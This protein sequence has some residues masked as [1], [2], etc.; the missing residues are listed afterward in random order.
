MVFP[1]EIELKTRV[2]SHEPVCAALAAAG[3]RRI[4]AVLETNHFFDTPEQTMLQR[5]AGLRVRE[6]IQVDSA[7]GHESE[8]RC[9]AGLEPTGGTGVPPVTNT[10]ETPVPQSQVSRPH[11]L[12]VEAP[13]LTTM[14]FKGA[15]QAGLFK[16]RG[17][18]EFV[19]DRAEAAINLLTAVGFVETLRF[20]KRRE[21]WTLGDC[22][23]ELD[24]LPQLGRF[25]EIEGPSDDTIRAV[26]LRLGLDPA[27]S[28]RESYA[29]LLAATIPSDSPRPL[30]IAFD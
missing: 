19:V 23:V 27:H 4:G 9:A 7:R 18:I 17:E 11:P 20:Q 6:A 24:E 14:T 2:D 10:G 13:S 29:A 25:V 16:A 22:N 3:A 5:G 12:P 28:I 21:S 1:L 15:Q 8:S 30:V 26:A